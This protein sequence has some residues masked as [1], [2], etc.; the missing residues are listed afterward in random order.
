MTRSNSKR[1]T[2]FAT[3]VAVTVAMGPIYALIFLPEFTLGVIGPV[4][5]DS[6]IGGMLLWGG[7][8]YLWPSKICA[9]LRRLAFPWH[10]LFLLVLVAIIIPMTGWID[11]FIHT[12]TLSVDFGFRPRGSLYLFVL[13][14]TAVLLIIMQ[15]SKV[16]GPRVL[17]NLLIGRYHNP[18]EEKRIF[19]FVDLIGSTALARQ[20]G[21]IGLQRLL[22]RFFF[23][24]GRP[25]AEH[26]GEIHAYIGDEVIITWPYDTGAER[27]R[28]VRCFFAVQSVLR[29]HAEVYDK[30][31]GVRPKI[32]AGL[33]GGSVIVSECGDTKKSIVYFGDTMNT[34]SRLE[35][36]AKRLDE[37]LIVS[38]QLLQTIDLPDGI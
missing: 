24:L 36:E 23:D 3:L 7:L 37:E 34:A 4:T 33:H 27:A 31:F 19:L 2:L 25:V 15:I 26:G 8:L 17:V 6:L 22:T 5:Q 9:P 1:L 10:I 13:A 21:D 12:G 28:C 38:E 16:I 18:V 35:S 29:G 11:R 30:L 32:R 20:H 14:V